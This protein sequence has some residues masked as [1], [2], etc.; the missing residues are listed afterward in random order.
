MF[1]ILSSIT[2]AAVAV[3]V[4]P[5]AVV[6]DVVKLPATADSNKHPF[7]HTK[8]MMG[9]AADNIKNAVDPE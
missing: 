5:L 3:A 2:K 4:T 7:Q 6:A 8:E 1:K 9:A